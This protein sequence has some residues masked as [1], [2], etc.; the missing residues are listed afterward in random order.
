MCWLY[1]IT[2]NVLG[3]LHQSVAYQYDCYYDEVERSDGE[4]QNRTKRS[5]VAAL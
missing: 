4:P 2:R 3:S 1:Y 5:R